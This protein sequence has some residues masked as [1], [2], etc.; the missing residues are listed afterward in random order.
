MISQEW[1]VKPPEIEKSSTFA[2]RLGVSPILAQLLIDRSIETTEEARSYLYPTLADLSDPFS[3]QDM[4][5]AVDRIRMAKEKG[6]QIWVYSF[7]DVDGTTATALLISIFRQ[8]DVPAEYYIADV[9]TEGY[10]LNKEVMTTLRKNGCN[11]LIAL[12]CEIASVNEVKLANELG[13]DVIIIHS[14][15]VHCNLLPSAHAVITPQIDGS[16][17]PSHALSCVAI[18]F[19]LA[20]ALMR[21]IGQTLHLVDL[22]D[23]VA[24][25]IV[26]HGA[27]LT[28]ENR[29][30][31]KLGLEEIKNR[32]RP[33]VRALCDVA[34]LEVSTPIVA[35]TLG[36]ALGSQINSVGC[37]KTASKVVQLLSAK[38]YET[39]LPIAQELNSDHTERRKKAQQVEEEAIGLIENRTELNKIKG[40]V[41]AQKGWYGGVVDVVASRLLERYHRPVFLLSI[42]DDEAYGFGRSTERVNLAASLNSVTH[43]FL[44]HRGHN[45]AAGLTIKTANIET[46]ERHFN[47]YAA[48]CLTEEN[49]LPRQYLDDVQASHVTSDAIEE[50]NLLEPF[51]EGNPPPHLAIQG[52]SLGIQ[53]MFEAAG[54]QIGWATD[55]L[56]A[57]K[58]QNTCEDSVD[59]VGTPEISNWY[60]ARRSQLVIED[61]HYTPRFVR[62]DVRRTVGHHALSTAEDKEGKQKKW[63]VKTRRVENRNCT[64]VAEKLEISAL[65][66]QL[67]FNRGIET[68]EDARTYLYPTSTDLHDPFLM[69]DMKKAVERI[70]S[71]KEKGERIWVY[72]DYDTDG[73]TAAA[74]L[75]GIFR[76][77]HVPAQFYIPNRFDEGYGLNKEAVIALKNEGCDLII[78]VDCG[79]TSIHEVELANEVG[80][81]V[82][83]TDHHQVHPNA[84]PPAH[85]VVTPKVLDSNYPFDGL[86][87][88]GLAFKLAHGLMGGGELTQPLV[89]QLDLVVLG[90]VVDMVTLTGENRTLTK[91]GLTEINRR[92]RPGIRALCDVAGFSRDKPIVGHTLGFVLGPRINAAGRMTGARKVVELLTAESDDAALPIAEQ[93]DADNTERREV[94]GRIHDTAIDIVEN[95]GSLDE[96]KGLVVAQSGWHQGVV[97]IVASRLMQRYHRPVFVLAIEGDKARGSGRSIEGLNLANSLNAAT[98]LLIKHGGHKAAAGLTIKTE[99]IPKF[100]EHFNQYACEHLSEEDL[101]P[102]LDLDLEVQASHLTLNAIEELKLLEPFGQDNPAPRLTL[103]GLTLLRTPHRVGKEK[104][105]LKLAVTD[106]RCRLEA[107]GWRKGRM[108]ENFIMMKQRKWE[109]KFPDIEKSSALAVKLG[110]SPILAQLLISRGIDTEEEARKYLSPTFA[111]LCNPFLI[112]DMEKAVERIKSAKKK[113]ER[114]WIYGDHDTN[115]T[116]ATALL[117]SIF[118]EFDVP[119]QSDMPNQFHEGCGLNKEAVKTLRDNGCGLVITVDRRN[120]STDEVQLANEIGLDVIVT[121]RHQPHPDMRHFAY[122]VVTPQMEESRHLSDGLTGVGLAFKLA[123]GLSGGTE[124]PPPLSKQLDL[125]VLGTVGDA[126]QLTG[127][128]RTLTALGL[129]EINKRNRPGIRA[130]CEVASF[131]DKKPIVGHTLQYVLGPRLNAAGRLGMGQKIVESL[132][133]KS[134]DVARPIVE[135][136]EGKIAAQTDEERERHKTHVKKLH[137]DFDVQASQLTLDAIDEL[138]L[139][140]PFGEENP[141]PQLVVRDLTLQRPPRLMGKRNQHLKLS[142]TDGNH[143]LDAIGWGMADF[144]VA[145]KS[146]NIRIDLAGTPEINEWQGTQNPQLIIKDIHIQTIDRHFQGKQYPSEDAESPVKILDYRHTDKK[147]YLSILLEQEEPIVFY[148]RD[149]KAIDRFLDLIGPQTESIGRCDAATPESEIEGLVG[150]LGNGKLLA[151]VS[152]RT[153]LTASQSAKHLVFCHPVCTPLAFYNRCQP[154]FRTPETTYIHLIYSA[155]DA[156]SMHTL[157]SWQYPDE[158]TLKRL[159]QT[160]KSLGSRSDAPIRLED[161]VS[162]ARTNSIPPDAVRNGMGI[163]EELKL[164]KSREQSSGKVVQLLPTPSEKRKLHQSRTYLY[165]EQ[166]KQTSAIFSEFQL[167]QSVQEIW[168]RVSYECRNSN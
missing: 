25:G 43:L 63:Q 85:A 21:S 96:V 87:G 24:L 140:E 93:L 68:A 129:K 143:M 113:G 95:E 149:E 97:G 130:L 118:R 4:E 94:E 134:Y 69:H 64:M 137:L 57:I 53:G 144:A 62:N 38:S 157:L 10:G 8:I 162:A 101:V 121:N 44:T 14:D 138:N 110:V 29:T 132:T 50:V 115:G 28:G 31:A 37:R 91:L 33:G 86:A 17:E 16:N 119:I 165:G 3:M 1:H 18:A 58:S 145:L 167:K 11:L 13:L 131:S 164:I 6:D 166:L 159:Y 127:E 73:T 15:H 99:N 74:L 9:F 135:E 107:L 155:K 141:S 54:W 146:K 160:I 2:D 106:G 72:G 5:T 36:I 150:T 66:A 83:I 142:V 151:I 133:T 117:L 120:T 88:V 112:N 147:S 71:A 109:V 12:D 23:L 152:S 128:N 35:H 30:L 26:A 114:I 82:I 105:H 154:A 49:L 100:K 76:D 47:Q 55:Y 80:M 126:G 102:K 65:T 60:G 75:L 41:I 168:K 7:G 19:K 52:P 158:E 48:E 34:F 103:K 92:K 104:E 20:H 108:A 39:A 153:L 139:L 161:V 78:T 40:L 89:N 27:K 70:H 67:L 136:L 156:D 116:T 56:L 84:L 124:F 111:D 125:V 61:L 77:L 163:F 45:T 123:H 32:R 79:I 122:A 81:D 22:L 46:F 59:L 98:H 148:V 90:T 42:E 51:G